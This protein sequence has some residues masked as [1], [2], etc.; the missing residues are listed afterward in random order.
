[1][2]HFA[3]NSQVILETSVRS[4]TSRVCYEMIRNKFQYSIKINLFYCSTTFKK[5]FFNNKIKKKN[6]KSKRKIKAV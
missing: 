3:L 5:K 1:M 2:A 6:A 4:I